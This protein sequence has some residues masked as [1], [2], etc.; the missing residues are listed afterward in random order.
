MLHK[1]LGLIRNILNGRFFLLDLGILLSWGVAAEENAPHKDDNVTNNHSQKTG[2]DSDHNTNENGDNDMHYN[3]LKEACDSTVSVAVMTEWAMRSL[4]M[5]SV[6]VRAAVM[7]M[8]LVSWD[9]LNS[10][11]SRL[12]GTTSLQF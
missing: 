10:W 4:R 2:C 11:D 7:A 6:G 8:G 9:T 3:T 1:A 12:L 5:L